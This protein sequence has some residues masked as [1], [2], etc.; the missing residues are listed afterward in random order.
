MQGCMQDTPLN[1]ERG[2]TVQLA[3]LLERAQGQRLTKQAQTDWDSLI[4]TVHGADMQS[5]VSR[6]KLATTQS[7]LT[8]DLLDIPSGS[9]RRVV[10][11]TIDKEGDTIHAPDS[12]LVTIQSGR[13]HT[14][15]LELLARL[16]SIYMVLDSVDDTIATVCASFSA[17]ALERST[18]LPRDR[19]L[20]MALDKIPYD[21]PGLLTIKGS[22]SAGNLVTQWQQP[23]FVLSR[24]NTTITASF[25]AVGTAAL[26]LV[27]QQPPVTLIRGR[28]SPTD[29]LTEEWQSVD[30]SLLIS[31]IMYTAGSAGGSREYLELYNSGE[32]AVV[33]DTLYLDISGRGAPRVLCDVSIAAGDFFVIGDEAMSGSTMQQW[34]VDRVVDLD[35]VSTDGCFFIRDKLGRL[36]DWV[37][38]DNKNDSQGWP[39]LSSAAKTAVVL[40]SLKVPNTYNNIGHQWLSAQSQLYLGDTLYYGTP[41]RGGR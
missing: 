18:C 32:K 37:A 29:S 4:V 38:F 39:Y 6:F 19:E 28:M 3:V 9:Q 13:T 22:D 11:W 17:G 21:Q 8:K 15:Q 26:N 12:Q 5:R 7:F 36:L 1:A 25:V 20:F 2:G 34:G 27:V 33:L 31:E 23:S 41:G 35:L 16:G 14:V 24:R 30:T 40:D 10:A